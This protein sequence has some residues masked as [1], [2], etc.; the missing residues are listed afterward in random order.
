MGE[1]AELG[2]VGELT[3]ARQK[4]MEEN[5]RSVVRV[6]MSKGVWKDGEE[7]GLVRTE[8]SGLGISGLGRGGRTGIR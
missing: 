5:S 7:I 3:P 4:K 6:H 8:G 2:W 1:P